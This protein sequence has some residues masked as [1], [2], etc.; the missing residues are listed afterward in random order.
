LAPFIMKRYLST[1]FVVE[2]KVE[3]QWGLSADKSLMLSDLDDIVNVFDEST[4]R[5]IISAH[6]PF[7]YEISLHLLISNF[8]LILSLYRCLWCRS[9]GWVWP[10]T[11]RWSIQES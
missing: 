11:W 2:A 8:S 3:Y 10:G 4:L 1:F 6:F 9:M 5:R 7:A